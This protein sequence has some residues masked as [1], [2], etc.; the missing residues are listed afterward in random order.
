VAPGA[1]EPVGDRNEDD[2]VG[3]TVI[4]TMFAFGEPCD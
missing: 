2:G 1:V 4:D 3:V